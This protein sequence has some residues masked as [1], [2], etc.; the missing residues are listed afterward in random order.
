VPVHQE[1]DLGGSGR[2]PFRTV[3]EDEKAE[4]TQN[5]GKQS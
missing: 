4:Y 2:V 5:S 1:V 3:G